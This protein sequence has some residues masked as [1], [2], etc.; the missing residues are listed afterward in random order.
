MVKKTIVKF[1]I[2]L[3]QNRHMLV[4]I[5]LWFVLNYLVL[6]AM[7][8]DPSQAAKY[9]FYLEDLETDYGHFYAKYSEFVVFGLFIGLV[10]VDAFRNY[11]PSKTCEI[12]ASKEK[13]HAIVFGYDHLGIRLHEYL[14]EKKKSRTS[15]SRSRKAT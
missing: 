7:S 14:N 10:T 15:S 12:L 6:L 2:T 13:N 3:K 9:L 4:L 5:G 11:D 8:G 1:Q